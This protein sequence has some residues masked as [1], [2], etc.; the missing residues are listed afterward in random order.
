MLWIST[1]YTMNMMS[2][3]MKAN[4]TDIYT[5][6]CWKISYKFSLYQNYM[7]PKYN[8]VPY[9]EFAFLTFNS[10]SNFSSIGRNLLSAIEILNVGIKIYSYQ[11]QT[12]KFPAIN[13]KYN[14]KS[15]KH[16]RYRTWN[17]K[18]DLHSIHSWISWISQISNLWRWQFYL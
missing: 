8:L 14:L 13:R 7:Y 5:I 11:F 18:I 10:N 12:L 16:G 9:T 1:S 3:S 17:M 2:N 4:L 15:F 6:N